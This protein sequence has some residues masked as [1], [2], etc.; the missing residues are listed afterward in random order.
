MTYTSKARQKTWHAEPHGEVFDASGVAVAY[1]YHHP[2]DA[3][4]IVRAVNAHDD[5]VALVKA[6]RTQLQAMKSFTEWCHDSPKSLQDHMNEGL[7]HVSDT[8]QRI[9]AALSKMRGD[10]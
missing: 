3:S 7:P 8:I 10:Q 2:R 5:L 1:I 4:I 6:A 9:D